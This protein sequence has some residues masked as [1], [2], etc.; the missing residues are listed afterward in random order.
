MS[1]EKSD[2]K[3]NVAN[4]LGARIEDMLEA[5]RAEVVRYEGASMALSQAG[6]ACVG[7]MAH[8]DKDLSDGSYDIPTGT[9]VKR[10]IERCANS[11]AGLQA[12]AENARVMAL[13]KI[14][15][16][17]AGVGILDKYRE[18]EASKAKRLRE[19]VAAGTVIV[20]GGEPTKVANGKG[21]VV[22]ARP[23]ATVKELRKR[24]G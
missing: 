4:D 23:G 1:A 18:E 6:K 24:H 12:Q 17:T 11:A 22:G 19:A 8:V 15:A 7:M 9:C 16:L 21:H 2:I 14:Q 13:G 3:I 10:Y 5:A 20:E